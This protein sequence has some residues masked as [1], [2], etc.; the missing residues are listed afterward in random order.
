VRSEAEIVVA[1]AGPVGLSLAIELRRRGLDPLVIE[2]RHE[3]SYFV[4]AL[5]ITPRMLEIW[6]QIGL[7]EEALAAGLFLRGTTTLRNGVEIES[8]DVPRQGYGYGMLALAQYDV[9]RILRTALARHGGRIEWGVTL[10]A[11]E[12]REDRVVASVRSE[13][14]G[15]SRVECGHLVGCDGAHSAVRHGLGLAYEGEAV[16]MT[17]MLGDVCATG[18]LSRGRVY[19]ALHFEDGQMVD[20]VVAVPIPGDPRR[21]RF[22]MVAPAP[23]WEDGADLTTPPTLEQ[24]AASVAPAFPPDVMLSELRWSSFYRISHRIVSR[25]SEG[26]C[27]LAGDA[28]HIH[29]PIGG[30]GMNTGVQDAFNLGWKLALAASGRASADLLQSYDAERRP[31]GLEVVTRT[32]SRMAKAIEGEDRGET[33][34]QLRDDSQLLVDYRDSPWVARDARV[35]TDAL[36]GPR[37]GD[38]AP[39]VR[40][41][42]RDYVDAPARLL[43]LLRHPGHTLFF[44]ADE[45]TEESGYRSFAAA[46]AELRRR[47]GDAVVCHGIASAGARRVDW[48][49]FPWSIDADGKFREAFRSS[50]GS[51]ELVRPDGYLAYRAPSTESPSLGAYLDRIFA[52]S[53]SSRPVGS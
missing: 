18:P 12:N 16:P 2:Q 29:P 37:P 21:Y 47:L 10:T 8:Q 43:D 27:F 45:R 26:R 42:K 23:Y 15:E 13:A 14:G 35:A 39:E 22:S 25:Y 20:Q 36:L 40:G 38:R 33:D 46:A 31:V 48:E 19:R 49:R 28:A 53:S 50:G 32:S 52:E 34:A 5:G 7:L 24:I 1:G 11:L 4:K 6:D 30:Q 17:F 9:E 41:L 51:L 3:P 44:Y